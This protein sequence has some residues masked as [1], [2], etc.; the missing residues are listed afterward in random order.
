MNN[1]H[2]ICKNLLVNPLLTAVARQ[3]ELWNKHNVR[4]AHSRSTAAVT[5]VDTI[6]LRYNRFEKG[7]DFVE[8]ICSEISCVNYQGFALLP[9]AMPLVFNIMQ[10]VNG[11]HLGRV[12]L[13]RMRPGAI[14][15][16][17]NDVIMEAD[18]QYPGK[19][20]PARYY[21][22]Y[23]IVLKSQPGVVFNCGQESTYM[24]TGDLWWFNN[25]IDHE[26]INNSGDDRIHLIVDI[27]AFKNDNYIP[28]GIVD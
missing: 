11:E 25:T 17:H 16:L 8:K 28:T 6:T 10:H 19:V 12:F 18:E 5:G 7:D 9:E 15:P 20:A 27:R 3:P 4:S 22:R 24:E 2:R 1:F 13:A 21:D 26:V 23:H 14:I